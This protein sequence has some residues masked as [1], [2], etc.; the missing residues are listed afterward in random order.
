MVSLFKLDVFI[1]CD[2]YINTHYFVLLILCQRYL[3]L[4]IFF[5]GF[6]KIRYFILE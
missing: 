1:K 3:L 5:K 4:F 2:Q 6:F